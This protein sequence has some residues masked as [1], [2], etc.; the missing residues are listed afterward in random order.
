MAVAP[1]GAVGGVPV[2][3][4]GGRHAPKT[5]RPPTRLRAAAC[6]SVRLP[7]WRPAARRAH[8]PPQAGEVKRNGAS[9]RLGGRGGCAAPG[10]RAATRPASRAATPG[11][12][13]ANRG[14]QSSPRR[15]AGKMLRSPPLGPGVGPRP[16][17]APR[18]PSQARP[19]F[20][21][22]SLLRPIT[23]NLTE[24]KSFGNPLAAGSIAGARRGPLPQPAHTRQPGWSDPPRRWP[25][26]PGPLPP[27]RHTRISRSPWARWW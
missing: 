21:A 17:D 19:A 5:K 24:T 10:R 3:L 18:H 2:L 22:E 25:R 14:K 1:R 27:C 6:W 26:G 8:A 20:A 9:S 16:G 23:I 12:P 7:R 4:A 11:S 13:A 15:A